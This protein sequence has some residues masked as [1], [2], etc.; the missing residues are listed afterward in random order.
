[1]LI[2]NWLRET[3]RRKTDTRLRRRVGSVPCWL[4]PASVLETRVLP[5][6][7]TANFVAGSLTLW[8]DTGDHDLSISQDSATGQVQVQGNNGTQI[9]YNGQTATS[10]EFD[11]TSSLFLNFQRGSGNDSISFDG[12]GVSDLSGMISADLGGGTNSLTLSNL[13]VDFSVSVSGGKGDNQIHLQ[14]VKTCFGNV[15]TGKGTDTVD[16]ESSQFSGPLT[17][18]T[19]GGSDTITLH[20]N[21]VNSLLSINGGYSKDADSVTVDDSTVSGLALL[22]TGNGADT[23]ESSGSKFT[24]GLLAFSNGG[25]DHVQLANTAVSS[26]MAVFSGGGDDVVNVKQTDTTSDATIG[27]TLID[28]G[29]GSDQIQ[30]AG[31]KFDSSVVL[32][33]GFDSDSNTVSID[34]T[35][36]RGPLVAQTFG[37][38]NVIKVEQNTALTGSTDFQS[39]VWMA[40]YGASGQINIGVVNDTANRVKFGAWTWF[41]GGSPGTVV[42]YS[43]GGTSFDQQPFLINATLD[44]LDGP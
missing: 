25:N 16:I 15:M 27:A 17:I 22:S 4:T 10:F 26:I 19:G 12:T 24:G 3:L 7:V 13:T 9:T 36:V 35:T 33:T 31:T 41:V 23:L 43:K 20:G 37:P 44:D 8:G 5:S 30:L 2:L 11:L 34:D 39:T 6:S 28:T 38:N 14:N 29:D 40:N 42:K 21:T 32:S 18:W 1:M